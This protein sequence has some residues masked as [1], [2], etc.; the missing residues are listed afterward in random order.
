MVARRLDSER[1]RVVAVFGGAFDPITDGHLMMAAEVVHAKLADAVW[2]VPCG[3]DDGIRRHSR[4][5]RG[6]LENLPTKHSAV[7]TAYQTPRS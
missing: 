6:V 4:T 5:P 7:K 2:V 1:R 3:K